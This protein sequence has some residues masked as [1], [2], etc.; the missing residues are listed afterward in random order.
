M[1]GL[2]RARPPFRGF[3]STASEGR[4]EAVP[5]LA[6]ARHI[7]EAAIEKRAG[8]GKSRRVVFRPVE[9]CCDP[10]EGGALRQAAVEA[11]DFRATA[12][13]TVPSISS[14]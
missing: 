2:S 8:V 10:R 7:G 11:V 6:D 9:Q 4:L 1:S 12:A 14:L 13:S 5:C 3:S